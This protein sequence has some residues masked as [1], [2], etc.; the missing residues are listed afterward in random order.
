MKKCNI[1]LAALLITSVALTSC[2]SSSNDSTNSVG[3][4]I[5]EAPTLNQEEKTEEEYTEQDYQDVELY[6]S[7]RCKMTFCGIKQNSNDVIISAEV[8]NLTDDTL[9]V[10]AWSGWV[11]NSYDIYADGGTSVSVNSKSIMNV[12]ISKYSLEEASIKEISDIRMDFYISDSDPVWGSELTR[13]WEERPED[14]TLNL[15]PPFPVE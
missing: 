9:F 12:R 2:G 14:I 10:E 13:N 15:D 5:I 7:S 11:I 3:N 1:L 8:E 6:S 4:I